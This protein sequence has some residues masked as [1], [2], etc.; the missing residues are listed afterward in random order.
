MQIVL[1]VI[2]MLMDLSVAIMHV[3]V[4]AVAIMQLEI[5][6]ALIQVTVSTSNMCVTFFIVFMQVGVSVTIMQVV[7]SAVHYCFC[8]KM[9][10]TI[11]VIAV[12]VALSSN[13]TIFLSLTDTHFSKN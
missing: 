12:W 8:C 6:A 2:V 7:I 1:S 3:T 9:R 11:S 5:S 13:S 4:V 10:V